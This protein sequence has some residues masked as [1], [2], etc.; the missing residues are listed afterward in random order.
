M[1]ISQRLTSQLC[2]PVSHRLSNVPAA[3]LVVDGVQPYVAYKTLLLNTG[4]SITIGQTSIPGYPDTAGYTYNDLYEDNNPTGLLTKENRATGGWKSY[5]VFGDAAAT[6]AR[7]AANPG[8]DIYCLSVAIGR[9]DT[10]SASGPLAIL[11]ASYNGGASWLDQMK[12]YLTARRSAGWNKIIMCT[13]TPYDTE[14]LSDVANRE[15]CNDLIR[16]LVGTGHIDAVCDYGSSTESLMGKVATHTGDTYYQDYVH[17]TRAGHRELYKIYTPALNAILTIATKT[18]TP[19]ISPLGGSYTEMK[20]ISI[21][22]ATEGAAIYYT[23]DGSTPNNTKTLYTAPFTQASGTIKAIAIKSGLTDSSINS[24]TF[25]IISGLY[26][27]S[28]DTLATFSADKK[29]A[30]TNNGGGLEPRWVR[31]NAKL[32][33]T[34]KYCIELIA[35]GY[36]GTPPAL[37]G[38]L[39]VIQSTVAIGS[40]INSSLPTVYFKQVCHGANTVVGGPAFGT[41]SGIWNSPQGVFNDG[42]RTLWAFDMDAGKAW[43]SRTGATWVLSG[44]AS[45]NPA[46][47]VQP[48]F[49]FTPGSNWWFCYCPYGAAGVNPA[50]RLPPAAEVTGTIPSGYTLLN[51]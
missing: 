22:C 23:L 14:S 36:T 29:T 33:S 3:L 27:N 12:S 39:G 15:L 45:S 48:H 47:G 6:D 44:L 38:G 51:A 1:T 42:D 7:I 34:G 9:N 43:Q 28:S 13:I 32:P 46:T 18:A 5:D 10:L 17:P 19:V 35:S 8:Q 11:A 4:D 20:T 41:A 25:T 37:Y 16:G 31:T 26:W 21:E 24:Q 50:W 2:L 49:T 40:S 30:T